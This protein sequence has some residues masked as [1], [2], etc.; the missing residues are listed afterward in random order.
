MS[1]VLHFDKSL[2]AL[3]ARNFMDEVLSKQLNVKELL[4]GYDNR[5]GHNRQEGFDDYVPIWA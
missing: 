4:I 2:A 5:F 3:S 1:F